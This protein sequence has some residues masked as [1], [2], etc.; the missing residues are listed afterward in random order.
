VSD[1][2]PLTQVAPPPIEKQIDPS[3]AP[4][5]TEVQDPGES[6]YKTSVH[7]VVYSPGGKVLS[8]AT[9]YSNY[10]ASPEILLVGPKPKPKA[11]PKPPATETTPTTPTTT[12]TPGQGLRALQ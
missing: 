4:G 8:D 3:L 10:V 2:A 9:W 7:R 12:T 1:A 11:K 6:A 5:T